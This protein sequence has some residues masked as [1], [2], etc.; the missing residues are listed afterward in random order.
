MIAA[1]LLFPGQEA[2]LRQLT[3]A[4]VAVP[5]IEMQVAGQHRGRTIRMLAHIDD[6][7]NLPKVQAKL[8]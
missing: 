3:Q 6:E 8:L 4:A 5:P 2:V 1:P 7:I